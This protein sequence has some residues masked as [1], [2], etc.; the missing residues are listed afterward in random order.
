MVRRNTFREHRQIPYPL[1]RSYL[2]ALLT[3]SHATFKIK[4]DLLLCNINYFPYSL[5]MQQSMRN[6]KHFNVLLTT[7]KASRSLIANDK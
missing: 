7:L 1:T 5:F 6:N 4:F 3:L 2:R